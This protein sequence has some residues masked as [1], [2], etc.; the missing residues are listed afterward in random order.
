MPKKSRKFPWLHLKKK[1]EQELPER[2]PMWMGNRSNGEYYHPQTREEKL[3]H[4]MVMERADSQARRLGMERREFLASSMGMFTTLAVINQVAGCGGD[5]GDGTMNVPVPSTNSGSGGLGGGG[6]VGAS[7]S[8]GIGSGMAGSTARAGAGAGGST[9]SGGSSGGGAGS[10]GSM[11][12]AGASGADPMSCSDCPY[13]VPVEATC[14][15][16]NLL[17]GD[18]EFIFDIQT[19]AFDDGEWRTKNTTYSGFLEFLATCGQ[20]LDC[21]DQDHYGEYMFVDSDTTVS[22]ITSWPAKLCVGDVT[23]ACGLPLSNEGMRKLRDD[24]NQKLKSQRVVNQIQV[25]PNDRWELQQEVMTMMASDPAWKAVS[26]KAYPAWGPPEG[27]GA[28][29]GEGYFMNSDLGRKF[30]EHGLSLG[31]PNFAIHKGLPIPGFDVEH[32]MPIEIGDLAKAYPQGNFIIYHSGVGANGGSLLNLAS[33]ETRFDEAQT[34]PMMH[35]GSNQFIAALRKAGITAENNTNVYGELGSA[36]SN[37]M[38]NATA[39]QHLIGKLLKYLGEDHVVWGTDCI[40]YGTPQP[41][42]ESF[43]R[44]QITPQFQ[45]MYGY[46]ELTPAI[47]AKI[48]GLNAAKVFRIDPMK[49]RCKAAEGDFATAKLQLDNELGPRR[50]VFREPLGPTT[51]REFMSLAR[52]SIAKRQPGA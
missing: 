13:V 11:A 4:R 14:E 25:M 30:I 43:R 52:Y 17:A 18:K 49:A 20:G 32:N 51:R 19:H 9:S 28:I 27:G 8:G 15:P 37:V 23:T 35:Q 41:Q 2:P 7:G 44:F 42:I 22:V 36:W 48:F 39:A 24:I 3:I 16:T 12:A 1:S 40:L 31:I 34:D 45:E 21:F 29:G 50:W 38:N 33:L 6:G 5:N 46:P 47:K 26:W 10:S